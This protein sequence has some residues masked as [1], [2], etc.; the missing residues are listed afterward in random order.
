M[1]KIINGK[2]YDTETAKAMGKIH[3]TID[4]STDWFISW[5]ERLYRKKSGEYFLYGYRNTGCRS[6]EERIT[7]LTEA[8]AKEWAEKCMEVDEYESVFGEVEE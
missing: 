7:P 2:K 6:K 1:R 5:N 3:L 8:K 4:L